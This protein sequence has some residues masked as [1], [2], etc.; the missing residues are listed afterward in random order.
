MW[1][2]EVVG[3]ARDVGNIVKQEPLAH[4]TVQSICGICVRTGIIDA[5]VTSWTTTHALIRV[6]SRA[7]VSATLDTSACLC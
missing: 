2:F 4:Q 6:P 5:F 3:G 1:S 7:T